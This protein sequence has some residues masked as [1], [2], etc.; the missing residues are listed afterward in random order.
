[1]ADACL[2]ERFYELANPM[3]PA[4]KE[5]SSIGGRPPIRHRIVLRVI[6]VCL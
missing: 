2:P 3:L 1:M 5:L 6:V 4:E